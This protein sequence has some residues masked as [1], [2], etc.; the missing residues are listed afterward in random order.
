[1]VRRELRRGDAGGVA[2]GRQ[3]ADGGRRT[4]QLSH[5]AT[6]NGGP[7]G[8]A[9]P[10][11]VHLHEIRLAARRLEEQRALYA[12]AFGL[13]ARRDDGALAVAIGGAPPLLARAEYTP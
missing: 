7:A 13:V 10:S 4:R 8:P 12:E 6:G 1:L 5:A 2:G 3:R 11:P 9:Y